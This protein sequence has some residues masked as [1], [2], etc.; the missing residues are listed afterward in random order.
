M[1]VLR[2]LRQRATDDIFLV[3]KNFERQRDLFVD[4]SPSSNVGVVVVEKETERA[5]MC[6]AESVNQKCFAMPLSAEVND[7]KVVLVS[8]LH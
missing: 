5:V 2:I 4:R 6:F 1:R 3:G 8:Y 7:N